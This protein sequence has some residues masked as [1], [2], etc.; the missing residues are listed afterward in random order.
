MTTVRSRIEIDAPP[1]R[2]WVFV[3]DP[4]LESAWNPKMVGISREPEGR[5]GEGE[6]FELEYV[7]SGRGSR[8]EAEVLE[9]RAPEKLVYRYH[10]LG[11]KRP[12]AARVTYT[13][14][15]RRGATRLVQTIDLSEMGIPW[16]L[17]ALIWLITRIGKETGVPYLQELK[18]QVEA[19]EAG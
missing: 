11:E 2:V 18:R 17:R 9:A 1:D 3:A 14:D 5:V 12:L 13:L 15:D 8:C 19:I 7:M 6:R 16:P 10:L 4:V